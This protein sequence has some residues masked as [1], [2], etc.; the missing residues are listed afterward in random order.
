M[1]FLSPPSSINVSSPLHFIF[2]TTFIIPTLQ[3]SLP[4]I[5]IHIINLHS[6]TLYNLFLYTIELVDSRTKLW[7]QFSMFYPESSRKTYYFAYTWA[8]NRKTCT[9]PGLSNHMMKI[10]IVSILHTMILIN[11]SSCRIKHQHKQQHYFLSPWS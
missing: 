8:S 4:Y 7:Y 2:A 11:N 1:D 6:F 3:I 10:F 5:S 9:Q